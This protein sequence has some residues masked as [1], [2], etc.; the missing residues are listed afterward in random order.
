M[1]FPKKLNLRPQ[2]QRH[3][4]KVQYKNKIIIIIINNMLKLTKYDI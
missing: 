3:C 2:R 1:L 4:G